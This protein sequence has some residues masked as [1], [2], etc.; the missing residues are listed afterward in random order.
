MAELLR[1]A[2]FLQLT[3]Q[4]EFNFAIAIFKTINAPGPQQT[5]RGV[6]IRTPRKIWVGRSKFRVPVHIHPEIK[7]QTGFFFDFRRGEIGFY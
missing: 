3:S 7:G 5:L 2:Q 4:K 6:Q 1:T